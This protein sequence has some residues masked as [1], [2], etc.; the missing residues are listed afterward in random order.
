MP[1]TLLPKTNSYQVE[2]KICNESEPSR[3]S[4]YLESE[5]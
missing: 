4:Q 5:A 3:Y 1:Y 2:S